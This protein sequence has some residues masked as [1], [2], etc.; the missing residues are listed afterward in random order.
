M[1][2]LSLIKDFPEGPTE[3]FVEGG[4]SPHT[5]LERSHVP[6]V[7]PVGIPFCLLRMIET[8]LSSVNL[9]SQLQLWSL[10]L[11]GTLKVSVNLLEAIFID[12]GQESCALPF[13]DTPFTTDHTGG[14][15][16]W[17]VNAETYA[18]SR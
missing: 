12:D 10:T 11:C 9:C 4:F 18:H 14:E 17:R 7:L 13:I 1:D 8:D 6:I 15:D 2:H 3:S 5:F 16:P